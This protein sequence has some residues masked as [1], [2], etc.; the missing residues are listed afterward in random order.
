ME[1]LMFVLEESKE[2]K[3]V[4]PKQKSLYLGSK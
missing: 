3:N 4:C 2:L 1:P